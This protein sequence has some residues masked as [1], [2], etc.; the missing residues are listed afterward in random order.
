MRRV[1]G[2]FDR[3]GEMGDKAKP[4]LRAAAALPDAL[5]E[6]SRKRHGRMEPLLARIGDKVL[7]QRWEVWEQAEVAYTMAEPD[8]KDAWRATFRAVTDFHHRVAD[9][10]R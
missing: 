1:Q 5:Q 10:M 2:A 4:Y 7:E 8:D 9:L 3:F 6:E